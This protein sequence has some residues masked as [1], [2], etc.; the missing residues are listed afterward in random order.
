[1]FDGV[2]VETLSYDMEKA[3]EETRAL[4]AGGATVIFEATFSTG[5][6]EVR[7]DILERLP[8]GWHIIEVKS[9][10]AE[11]P[12]HLTD[13]A[14]QAHV[15]SQCGLDVVRTSLL[16]IDDNYVADGGDFDAARFFVQVDVTEAV[17]PLLPEVRQRLEEHRQ[18]VT[19]A[20]AP[21]VV[22]N[23]HCRREGECP[24]LSHCWSGL[25]RHDVTTLPYIKAETVLE[26]HAIGARDLS[27]IPADIKLS[28]RQRLIANVVRTNVPFVSPALAPALDVEYPLHFLDFESS[29]SAIPTHI[30]VAPYR[31]VPFQWS[32]HVIES[33][34][35]PLLHF[36][37]LN[38]DGT[39]PRPEF[40][41][42]LWEAVRDAGTVCYY[43]SYEKSILKAL[44]AADVPF[45]A[46]A[47]EKLETAGLDL[48]KVVKDTV[49]LP[50]FYGRTSIKKVYPALVPSAGYQDLAIQDGD[51]A[52]V[53]FRRM[54]SPATTPEEA[55]KIARALLDYCGR[56]TLAMVEVFEAL[57]RLSAS[58]SSPNPD[59]Y[60]V[61]E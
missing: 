23:V 55:D 21:E 60:E 45:A 54:V 59:S 30:G 18:A 14:F 38:R 7:A 19:G 32:N 16:L 48:E 3:V 57:R 27:R 50:E 33:E 37:F 41:R 2:L 25:S 11:K 29:N 40:A 52:A 22:P 61:L 44:A 49:Y 8:E 51:M 13:L 43:S 36:E 24:Y 42:T 1:M 46:Q 47:L 56:D 20:T 10:K 9:S 58:P 4:I 26:L 39:D 6:A 31:H 5:D 35:G 17:L 34:G 28:A 53:E 15:L 12:E